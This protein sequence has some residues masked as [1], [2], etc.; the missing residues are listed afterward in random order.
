MKLEATNLET[1]FAK[2]ILN[3]GFGSGIYKGLTQLNYKKE[4]NSK[5]VKRFVQISLKERRRR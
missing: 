1:I 4:H 3:R 5:I 2:N